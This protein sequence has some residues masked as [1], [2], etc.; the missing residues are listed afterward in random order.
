MFQ[1]L[2]MVVAVVIAHAIYDLLIYWLWI[3][4]KGR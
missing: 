4:R 2:L 3:K 1:F